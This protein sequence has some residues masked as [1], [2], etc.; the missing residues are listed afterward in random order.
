MVNVALNNVELNAGH[1]MKD[2]TRLEGGQC[3]INGDRIAVIDS[4]DIY[5]SP[6]IRR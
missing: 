4:E 1:V 6:I 2:L 3:V 5:I